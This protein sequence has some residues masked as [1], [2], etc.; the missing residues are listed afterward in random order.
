MSREEGGGAVG[1]WVGGAEGR[2]GGRAVGQSCGQAVGW[3]VSPLVG[4]RGGR[5]GGGWIGESVDCWSWYFVILKQTV[6]GI[7]CCWRRAQLA[8]SVSIV[9]WQRISCPL[10]SFQGLSVHRP[11]CSN[12]VQVQAT[13]L[14]PMNPLPIS[15]HRLNC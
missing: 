15:F 7:I 12:R 13:S 1:G 8:H 5:W 6:T 11:C 4:Q 10:G 3:L 14:C 9:L 2:W